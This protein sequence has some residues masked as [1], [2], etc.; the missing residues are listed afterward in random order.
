MSTLFVTRPEWTLLQPYLASDFALPFGGTLR[1][2]VHM[3]LYMC[4]SITVVSWRD[5]Q[6]TS[7]NRNKEKR[8][9]EGRMAA[10]QEPKRDKQ[11]P[12]HAT[13]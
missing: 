5:A 6:Q 7:L 13:S 4:V 3:C 2:S 9:Q 1:V 11:C 12:L 10:S 8:E